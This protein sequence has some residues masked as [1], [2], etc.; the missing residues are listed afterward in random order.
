MTPEALQALAERTALRIILSNVVAQLV[1]THSADPMER[2]A[3]LSQMN[4]ECKLA[5]QQAMSTLAGHE[6]QVLLDQMF[7]AI[8]EFFKGITIT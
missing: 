8:D 3:R 5:A 7:V 2:R 1:V 4:D 6:R